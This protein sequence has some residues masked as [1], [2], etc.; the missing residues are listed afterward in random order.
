MASRRRAAD[1]GR[2]RHCLH[3]P[4][5]VAATRLAR[6]DSTLR[7]LRAARPAT[8]HAPKTVNCWAAARGP[9]SRRS[10]VLKGHEGHVYALAALDG[11]RLAS[12]SYD[13]SV[14]IW[15]LA[16]GAQQDPWARLPIGIQND[17]L[18]I[19]LRFGPR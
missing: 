10:L 7:R 1:S 8:P 12:G 5:A 13:R 3:D 18:G 14:I 4:H 6:R 15:H 19:E 11:G 17:D 2:E 9:Y 16:D